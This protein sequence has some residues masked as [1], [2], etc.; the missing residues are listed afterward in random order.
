MKYFIGAVLLFVVLVL[1]NNAVAAEGDAGTVR[2]GITLGS[3][4]F[5]DAPK[6]LGEFCEENLG[7]EGEYQISDTVHIA[8]GSYDN[9]VCE[10]SNF[11]GMGKELVARSLW[12]APIHAGLEIGV[13]DGYGDYLGADGRRR[14][15]KTGDIMLMGG[16][17]ARIGGQHSLK[18][19]YMFILIAA[20]YQYEFN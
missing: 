16:P 12:G 13:A 15:S 9:S 1:A 17:Y 20:S 14:W 4:H 18:L 6:S 2:V 3:K 19:R 5:I 11:L 10:H 7:F 8:A